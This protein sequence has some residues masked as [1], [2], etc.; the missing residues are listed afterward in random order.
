[1]T[2]LDDEMSRCYPVGRVHSRI[3]RLSLVPAASPCIIYFLCFIASTKALSISTR[4]LAPEVSTAHLTRVTQLVS[5]ALGDTTDDS[6]TSTNAASNYRYASVRDA[7][8]NFQA[9]GHTDDANNTAKE[10]PKNELVYGE[11]SVPVLATILD[12]VGVREDDVFLDIGSGDGALV[13]GASLLYASCNGEGGGGDSEAGSSSRRRR[14]AIRKCYG[15]DVVP[16]LVDRSVV[17]SKNLV[18]M[19]R[20]G[21]GGQSNNTFRDDSNIHRLLDHN[22]AEVRFLL[23]DIHQP[24]DGL[25]NVLK[26]TTLA[27]CFATTWSAGNAHSN[28]TDDGDTTKQQS[29]TKSLQGRRLPKLS[30]ALSSTRGLT[31]GCRVVI[32]D[33]KLDE[34]D[35]FSWQGD[36]R[37]HCPDTA[38]YS[39]ATL[40]HYDEL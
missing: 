31:S 35:G 10:I 30:K 18:R 15:V 26:E 4:S 12:A 20:E 37:I 2:R 39:V 34:E 19:L 33:G 3:R 40:Y 27:V 8:S 21:G 32:I 24:H 25:Q 1:M 28:N 6:S 16:G 36:L 7:V 13:L 14:N 17:H 29:S 23:G 5:S 22:Q 9:E 11:L 38:P